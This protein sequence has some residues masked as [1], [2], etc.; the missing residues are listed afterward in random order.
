VRT[1]TGPGRLASTAEHPFI[2]RPHPG[3]LAIGGPERFAFGLAQVLAA[4]HD[5]LEPGGFMV[6][7]GR[8]YRVSGVLI[9]LPGQLAATVAACGF[10]LY[11]RHV[12][13][14]ASWKGG[15]LRP[16]HSF[17]GLHHARRLR[18]AGYPAHLCVHEDVIVA[19]RPR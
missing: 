8:P 10:D 19:R 6:L 1:Y 9:D 17:F 13:L 14:L 7:T 15:L 2:H 5:V 3:Q 4:C 11:A 16:H 18:R 12:A